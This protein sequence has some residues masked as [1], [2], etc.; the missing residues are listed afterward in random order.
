M[1]D[2]SAAHALHEVGERH[3]QILAGEKLIPVLTAV[4]AVLA[5]L[6]TLF[7]H[8]S[9]ILALA[10]KNEGILLQS[11]AADQ[12]NY[13]E[14]K[15]IKIQLDQALID[16]GVAA[17]G[18]SGRSRMEQRMAKED[19]DAKAILGKAK[20]LE[21]QSGDAQERSERFMGSYENHEIAATLF[22]VSIVLV[23]V[24]AL[25]R[26]RL[27]LIVAGGATLVGLGFLTVGWLR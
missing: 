26:T 7:A 2:F 23:S 3:E 25:M 20:Q 5:A 10:Q 22:E 4:I 19:A 8:H 13:Y 24:T 11:K 17:A 21:L 1:G 16:A 12:Y 18:T 6:A 27:F 14:S 15:R 9:S